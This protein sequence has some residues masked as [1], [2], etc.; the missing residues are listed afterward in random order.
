MLYILTLTSGVFLPI[1]FCTGWFG[2]NFENMPEL[3]RDAAY[4]I[5]G[6]SIVLIIIIV[7]VAYKLCGCFDSLSGD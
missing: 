1:T 5:F 4:P 2:M 7:L 3:G 6:S